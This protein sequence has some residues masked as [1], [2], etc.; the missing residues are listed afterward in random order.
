MLGGLGLTGQLSVPCGMRVL[1][2]SFLRRGLCASCSGEPLRY[3]LQPHEA[4]EE[5]ISHWVSIDMQMV[6][7]GH[8]DRLPTAIQR[9]TLCLRDSPEHVAH[10]RVCISNVGKGASAKGE[11]LH[12]L[13]AVTHAEGITLSTSEGARMSHRRFGGTPP[14]TEPCVHQTVTPL[15][16][17]PCADW[18]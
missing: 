16:L 18:R 13:P 11:T 14:I 4:I 3:R 17:P 10:Q 2:R 6:F 9:A 5:M 8:F 1:Q 7:H 12:P 15:T